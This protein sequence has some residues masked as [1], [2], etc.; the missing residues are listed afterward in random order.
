MSI[1]IWLNDSLAWWRKIFTKPS[2]TNERNRAVLYFFKIRVR[3]GNFLDVQKSAACLSSAISL[4]VSR[5]KLTEETIFLN[6][7]MN[8]G[9]ALFFFR[10]YSWAIVLA[11]SPV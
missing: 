6:M 5:A 4:V 8:S 2:Y 1:K 9:H 7:L 11:K 3:R 10:Q